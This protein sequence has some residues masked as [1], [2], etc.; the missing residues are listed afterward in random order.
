MKTN[1][2]NVVVTTGSSIGTLVATL[3]GSLVV[4][5]VETPI[6]APLIVQ[7]IQVILDEIHSKGM[8]LCEAF[9]VATII[10]KLCEAFQV[11]TIIEKL[12]PGWKDF[13]NYLKHKQ[14]E[15]NVED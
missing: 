1:Q 14:K 11:A 10:E 6:V 5:L 3:N 13:R 8:E 4:A 7:E 9:Q 15:M 12:P 2:D